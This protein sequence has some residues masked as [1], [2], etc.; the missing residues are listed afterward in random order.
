LTVLSHPHGRFIGDIDTRWLP[1]GR[2]ML[3]LSRVC[4]ED[5]R[6]VEW[7]ADALSIVDGA[8]IPRFFWRLLGGP[9]EGK[10]R[11]ASVLHDVYCKTRGLHAGGRRRTHAEV[12]R[13]FYDG[14][15]ARNVHVVKA[16]LMWK[17]VQF[18]GPRWDRKGRD[19][20]TVAEIVCPPL[21]LW[22][23]LRRAKGKA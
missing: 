6:L 20:W 7:C 17:A 8:S 22:R 23:C 4:Y 1:D 2:S 21:R 16:W 18:D 13:M 9:L 5:P 14:M 19:L 15:R 11:D 12:H 3:L 10:Y